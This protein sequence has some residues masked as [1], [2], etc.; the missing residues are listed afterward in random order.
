M[1]VLPSTKQLIGSKMMDQQ[2]DV[3]MTSKLKILIYHSAKGV[4][5]EYLHNAYIVIFNIQSFTIFSQSK[6]KLW[7]AIWSNGTEWDWKNNTI[8]NVV[9][10]SQSAC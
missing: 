8:K 9:K 2:P 10:V 6:S 7:K 4:Q 1:A 3:F 5:I